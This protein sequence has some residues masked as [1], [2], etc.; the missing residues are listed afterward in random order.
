[1]GRLCVLKIFAVQS[2]L[3]NYFKNTDNQ[4]V[5]RFLWVDLVANEQLK[6]L[7]ALCFRNASVNN[8]TRQLLKLKTL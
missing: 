8:N 3:P 6:K 2:M 5:P 1:M 7:P 4:I